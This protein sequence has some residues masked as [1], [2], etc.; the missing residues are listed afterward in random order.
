[1][2]KSVL[3]AVLILIS[4]MMYGQNLQ[5][6]NL[7]GTHV[8]TV[9]L[10]PGITMEKYLDFCNTKLIPEMEKAMPGWKCYLV[11]GLRG[12]NPDSY[13]MIYVIKSQADRDK[14]YNADGTD[15]ELGKKAN[16]KLKPL[17]DELT[18][19]GTFTTKYT[20]WVVL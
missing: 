7:I 20:D 15:S 2:K 1:M 5:K 8:M 3:L 11:K 13:G 12:E 6:G 4:G 17:T 19:M 18:K 9:T 14:Y 10:N 16:E